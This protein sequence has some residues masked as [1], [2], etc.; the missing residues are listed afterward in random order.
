VRARRNAGPAGATAAVL[1]AWFW[2]SAGA[3][4]GPAGAVSRAAPAETAAAIT[5]IQVMG[6]LDSTAWAG[7][8]LALAMFAGDSVRMVEASAV[9]RRAMAT[10]D[11]ASRTPE[12]ILHMPWPDRVRWL[13]R[14]LEEK[15]V[16][17]SRALLEGLGNR[18]P[19]PGSA[20]AGPGGLAVALSRIAVARAS[21]EDESVPGGGAVVPD[22]AAADSSLA[23]GP[24]RLAAGAE[25]YPLRDEAIYR[26]WQDAE[27]DG[28]TAA[29]VLWADS[30]VACAPR[31]ARTPL[32]RITRARA[33]LAAG[34]P[35]EA[36]AEAR[37]ALPAAEDAALDAF[38]ARALLAE[39][40]SREAAFELETLIGK[41]G[42]DPLAVK[43]F[44]QR[45]ALGDSIADLRLNLE[46][47]VELMRTLLP[48]PASGA[49]EATLAV[50]DDDSLPAAVRE[51]AGMIL[52]RYFYAAKRY[53][54]A[55][56][57]L[58]RLVRSADSATA[59]EA[60][61]IQ[62][63]IFRNTGR[64]KP[65]EARYRA[66]METV[67][68]TGATATWELA[69]E[70]ESRGRWKDAEKVY[71]AFIR[72]YP[73]HSH[74]RDALFRRGF[75]RVRRGHEEQAAE[76]FRAAYRASTSP[77]DQE[78]A[79]YWLAR[80]LERLGR[81]ADAREAA[82]LGAWQTEPKDY[83]GVLIRREFDLRGKAPEP[84]DQL[85]MR[86]GDPLDLLADSE[87]GD[88]IQGGFIRG[89]TLARLGVMDEA[90]REWK[91]VAEFAAGTPAAMQALALAATVHHVYPEAVFW[92]G[93]SG[94]GLPATFGMRAGYD[95]LTFPAAYYGDVRRAAA[96]TGLE[97]EVL[98]AVMRQES[99][100]DPLAVSR[101][102][103]IGL[104]Q[105]MPGTLVRIGRESG[106]AP[107][108]V[109]ALY[110]ADVNVEL[111]ARFFADR[112][113]EFGGKLLPA[114]ASYNA[115]EAKAR[116]WLK[117]AGGDSGEVFV[118]CIGYPETY[119]YVRRIVWLAWVY[120]NYYTAR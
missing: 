112:L 32:V 92:A 118:E 107:M 75:D 114:L 11:G 33:L 78:Q 37:L 40:R 68:G 84:P 116:E 87:W 31:S 80:T 43:A 46:G 65:M 73:K 28:D 108:P 96:A 66:L 62:A 109:D 14:A 8:A 74:Y 99:L 76:D 102:G 3:P 42:D 41:Y 7:R 6:A 18:L 90:R 47:R 36:V 70:I 98:W 29:A 105:I 77:P 111:G 48:Q 64:V 51:K 120:R 59:R 23:E 67:G 45:L 81:D 72:T 54:E 103:A 25:D 101:A 17:W 24:L 100:Y 9:R 44:G 95:R 26:L 58:D 12:I 115:G 79:G 63:R 91:R 53:P 39:G 89:L 38:I 94:I 1:L 55:E 52:V 57:L 104:L 2:L 85:P 117:R 83:Y 71:G 10:L 56:P 13:S 86:A 61:L 35:L 82:T 113:A 27:A 5:P 110:R 16:D 30:L 34:R 106:G 22:T 21:V 93:R 119:R 20:N 88:P 4:P 49:V 19:D 15:R 60:G 69:R 50:A 97:P